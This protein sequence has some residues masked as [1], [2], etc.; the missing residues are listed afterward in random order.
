MVGRAKI[1]AT[2]DHQPLGRIDAVCGGSLHLVGIIKLE[3]TI[4]FPESLMI[5]CP[6]TETIP[7]VTAPITGTVL[8]SSHSHVAVNCIGL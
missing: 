7:Y 8:V 4:T 2:T 5:Q 1:T 3:M 6:V